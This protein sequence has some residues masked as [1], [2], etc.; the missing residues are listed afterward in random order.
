[1]RNMSF[2]LT[3]AAMRQRSKTVTRRLG[4]RFA[5]P[6]M[7]VRAVRQCRGLKRGEKVEP[8]CVIMFMQVSLEE[9]WQIDQT[10]CD[11]EGFPELRPDEFVQMFCRAMRCKPETMVTRIA[12]TYVD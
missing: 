11:W 10:E 6:G 5:E 1:M 4:W 8:I 12:F 9:L 7:R 2:K 3:E